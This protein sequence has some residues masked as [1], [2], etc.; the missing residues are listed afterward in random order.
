MPK[1][2]EPCFFEGIDLGQDLTKPISITQLLRQ[3][4]FWNGLAG[5]NC[6]NA[7]NLL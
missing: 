4:I 7:A 5:Q 3:M 6:Q 1:A 2:N